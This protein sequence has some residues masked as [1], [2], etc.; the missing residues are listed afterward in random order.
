MILPLRARRRSEHHTKHHVHS[1]NVLVV[2]L[3]HTAVHRRHLF[4]S[5]CVAATYLALA[6]GQPLL[7]SAQR[8]YPIMPCTAAPSPR[9]SPPRPR[10][11]GAAAPAAGWRRGPRRKLPGRRCGAHP[12][13]AA[14]ERM[15]DAVIDLDAALARAE[16]P[17]QPVDLRRADVRRCPQQIPGHALRARRRR[18]R[19]RPREVA[20]PGHW[21]NKIMLF[22]SAPKN[23]R[24]AIGKKSP[25]RGEMWKDAAEKYAARSKLIDET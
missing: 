19:A 16:R 3:V 7:T 21:R 5:Q 22:I 25:A 12:D 1:A 6:F 23:R 8:T 24:H 10:V 18:Q 9:P 14:V 4:F 20:A 2:Y 15:D 11:P 13:H 17:P